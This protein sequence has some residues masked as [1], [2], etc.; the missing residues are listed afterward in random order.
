MAD[1]LDLQ[2]ERPRAASGSSPARSAA[3]HTLDVLASLGLLLFL[4]P[5]LVLVAI[6]VRLDSRGPILFR[7]QRSGLRGEPF[8]IFKFRS[9]Y[10]HDADHSVR[11]AVRGDPRIT[12]TGAFLRK[13]SIDELP[14][15]LNVLRGDM[16]LVGPRP[17]ALA[18]DRRFQQ[19]ARNYEVRFQARPGITGLAQVNGSRGEV[20]ND[21]QIVQRSDFDNLYVQNWSLR[22]DVLIM[23]RTAWVM[24]GD[25][26][27]Y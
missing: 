6:A 23:L 11:Q 17:H 18:H 1:L 22:L 20:V 25:K 2:Y 13:T 24:L 27:A 9:M 4:A 3:K 7:Q 15:L 5:L 21:E 14:Q 19:V 16:S 10:V 12:R 8:A 26:N